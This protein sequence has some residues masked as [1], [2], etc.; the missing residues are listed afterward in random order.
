[1]TNKIAFVR[2]NMFD[3]RSSDAMEPLVFSILAA[4]TPETFETVLWD[5]RLEDIPFDTP[6]SLIAMTVETYTAKR[7]YQLAWEFRRRGV[8]IVMGGYH[9]TFMPDEVLEHCD[10]I[11]MG[12]AEGVWEQVLEDFMSGQLCRKY[13]GTTFKPI[14][15]DN[16]DRSIY[17]GKKYAPVNLVQYGRGCKFNC[18]FC[19]IRAFYGSN[20]R[21]R[22]VA[23]IVSEIEQLERK[24]IFLVDD[25]IFVDTQ[26][27][28]E[29]F[30]ALIPLKKK[31]SC[32]VSID[33]AQNSDLVKLMAASGC[34]GALIGFE[35]LNVDSLRQMKKGWGVKHQTYDEAIR[36]FQDAGIMIYGTFVF[37]Y[38]GDTPDS[39]KEAV[40]FAV[41]NKF[42]LAN[43]NP[44]TPT[45]GAPLYDRLMSEN[46]L[47]H[48]KWWLDETFRYGD[49][50]FEPLG[51]TAQQLTDGCYWARTEFNTYSS[52]FNRLLDVR[53]NINSVTRAGFYLL[54]NLTSRRE[55]HAKQGRVLGAA[56]VPMAAGGAL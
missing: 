39:F 45:P 17:H 38:D 2:P 48:D 7:A 55:I 36:V 10:A 40:E 5:E 13:D 28:R 19:S 16:Q 15:S 24:H 42:L 9:P 1:M 21:Q 6:V 54:S 29:L 46:R 31:W 18:D 41:R 32:Q 14:A 35:S 51:M 11:V 47:L 8:P 37:G 22:S 56:N 23:D 34:T 27:A 52:I 20:L 25:N 26:K 3:G 30:H 43:F 49:A 44:L 50:T 53:T 33:I 12:D 4:R